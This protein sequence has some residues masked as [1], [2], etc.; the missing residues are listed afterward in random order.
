M[1]GRIIWTGAILATL[2]T[3]ASALAQAGPPVYHPP[4]LIKQGTATSSVAGNGTVKIQ[5]RVNADGSFEV[6]KIVSS[7]NH[8]DDAAALEM[9]KSAQYAPA[10]KGGKKVV[11]FYTYVLRFV[12]SQAQVPAAG[13]IAEFNSEVHSGKYAEAKSGLTTY[14]AAHPDDAQANAVLGVANFFLNDYTGAAAA[15]DKA[16]TVP[17][18]YKTVAANAYVHAAEDALANKN[19]AVAVADATKAN[20]L[21][22]GAPT[23]NLLG[24]AQ[25][26]AGD[27]PNAI[28]SLDQARATAEKEGKMDAK[29]RAVISAN[30]VA[31]YVDAGQIDKA[32]AL[33]P[34][35]K[36]LD[37]SNMSA[38]QRVAAY[39]NTKGQAEQK[40]G[41]VQDA[42]AL[43]EKGAS[44]GSPDAYILY[45][46]EAVAYMQ[47]VKPDWSSAK[48]AADKALALKPDD[49]WANYAAGIALANGGK[50]S[51]AIP[52][53]RKAEASAKASGNTDLATKAQEVLTRLGDVG[54]PQPVLA[55]KATP[56]VAH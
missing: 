50:G 31:A 36:Q 51:E 25:I 41:R 30:L 9:A 40:A 42:I 27:Y 16:G 48:A 1:N 35:I 39:Y 3:G 29:Q 15:F 17:P 54:Y 11:A 56:Q 20:Q 2:G 28:R 21:A 37:P 44:F 22:P 43:Y 13:T 52:Y 32:T 10:T 33:L 14:L 12:G 34:E 5:V 45:T 7:T 19:G 55:P 26:I 47:N 6:Q 8:G 53:L 18:Q 49:G 24:N 23:L 46:N 4:K 38:A